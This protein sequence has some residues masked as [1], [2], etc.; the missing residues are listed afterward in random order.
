[1]NANLFMKFLR[2]LGIGILILLCGMGLLFAAML[3]PDLPVPSRGTLLIR[4]VTIL[5]PGR[6]A[7]V[8]RQ[9]LP[10]RDV[11]IR[12]DRIVEIGPAGTIARPEEETIEI[13]GAGRFLMPGLTDMHVHLPPWTAIG[14]DRLFQLMFLAHGVTSIREMGATDEHVFAVREDVRNG[15][16]PGARIFAAGRLLDGPGSIWPIARVVTGPEDAETAVR[17]QLAV[18]A[19]FIK[20]YSMLDE[21]TLEAIQAAAARHNKKVIGHIPFQIPFHRAGVLD[22]QH[23]EDVFQLAHVADRDAWMR[24]SDRKWGAVSESDYDYVVRVSVEQGITHTPTLFNSRRR[25]LIFD[26]DLP[27]PAALRNLPAYF[28]QVVWGGGK[29]YSKQARKERQQSVIRRAAAQCE[30][31]HRINAAGVRIH[32]GTDILMPYVLPGES[33]HGEIHTLAECGLSNADALGTATV[34]A[35]EF[36]GDDVGRVIAGGRADLLLLKNDP[37]IDL[38]ALD[39][40]VAVIADGRFYKQSELD[41]HLELYRKHFRGEPYHSVMLELTRLIVG[42]YQ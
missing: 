13:S 36:F 19:D 14:N 3:P 28:D 6:F 42:F 2:F 34:T 21:Q 12:A 24:E 39:Q 27:K 37:T 30:L 38:S 16:F 11:L 40:R 29:R 15:E 23:F 5:N 33:L 26:P 4:N 25:S 10:A 32:A 1:M 35:G 22:V 17:E 18:G 8:S 9:R 7:D 31:V 20:T 41:A